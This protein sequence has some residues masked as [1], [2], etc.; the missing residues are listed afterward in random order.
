[1][2]LDFGEIYIFLLYLCA[3]SKYTPGVKCRLL[4]GGRLDVTRKDA[5]SMIHG[6]K[7][8]GEASVK[9]KRNARMNTVW[10]TQ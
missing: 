1:M 3:R 4:S 5:M 6:N 7:S 8:F 2:R 10:I 9:A